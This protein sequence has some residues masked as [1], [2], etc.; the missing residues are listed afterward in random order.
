MKC[1][2]D[3]MLTVQELSAKLKISVR[4]VREWTQR[5][6]IPFTRIHHRI[7]FDAG[8]VERILQRNAVEAVA[9][10]PIQH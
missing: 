10:S 2:L 8:V 4:T 1:H 7:Y 3:G 5:R 9:A 6:K